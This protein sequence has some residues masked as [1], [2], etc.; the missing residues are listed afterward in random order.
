MEAHAAQKVCTHHSAQKLTE[1]GANGARSHGSA[2]SR[3]TH[4]STS[5]TGR[6]AGPLTGKL[7]TLKTTRDCSRRKLDVKRVSIV[8]SPQGQ[9]CCLRLQGLSSVGRHRL[10]MA[11][12]AN[13]SCSYLTAAN[14][15]TRSVVL[16]KFGETGDSTAVTQIMTMM[17]RA[18]SKNCCVTFSGQRLQLDEPDVS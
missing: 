9:V 10:R 4:S 6:T 18:A 7:L 8:E 15:G 17:L 14:V 2:S 11:R 13:S 5:T 1:L 3:S 16:H 12:A